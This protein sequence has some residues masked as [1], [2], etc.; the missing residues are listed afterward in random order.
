MARSVQARISVIHGG[1]DK[2]FLLARLEP[3]GGGDSQILST[4]QREE[5][6]PTVPS[7]MNAAYAARSMYPK[8]KDVCMNP[9]IPDLSK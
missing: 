6:Y 7:M 8:K 2:V 4:K 9:N 3:N 5:M 1:K